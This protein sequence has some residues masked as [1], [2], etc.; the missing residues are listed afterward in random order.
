MRQHARPLGKPRHDDD[1][2]CQES[3]TAD[4]FAEASRWRRTMQPITTLDGTDR[5][6]D[7]L[8][9]DDNV[10]AADVLAFLLTDCGYTVRTAYDGPAAIHAADAWRP[11]VAVLDIKMPGAT[12]HEVA[13]WIRQQPWGRAT[14]LI[15]LTAYGSPA[16]REQTRAAGFDVHLVK[17]A[18]PTELIDIL[19]ARRE[20]SRLRGALQ[21]TGSRASAGA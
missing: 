5:A 11:G 3:T 8:V 2:A 12:G 21:A 4:G 1:D 6:S 18:S 16:D 20:T 9:A 19:R 17:P 7:V 14:L 10:D 15:A 13:R